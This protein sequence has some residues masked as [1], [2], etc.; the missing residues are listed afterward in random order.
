M[1]GLPTINRSI[2]LPRGLLLRLLLCRSCNIWSHYLK[3]L[4]LVNMELPKLIMYGVFMIM[5]LIQQC[6]CHFKEFTK[7]DEV[8][9]HLRKEIP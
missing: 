9:V 2:S 8:L 5:L 3:K 7:V 6:H 1:L 4:K